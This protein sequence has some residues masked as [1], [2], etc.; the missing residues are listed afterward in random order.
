MDDDA[1]PA[2]RVD[3]RAILCVDQS[4]VAHQGSENIMMRQIT[5]TEADLDNAIAAMKQYG[6]LP[7]LTQCCIVAQALRRTFPVFEACVSSGWW[8]VGPTDDARA[9]AV[10]GASDIMQLFDSRQYAELRRRLPITI[11]ASEPRS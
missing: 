10:R 11:E 4:R 5:V 8:D 2:C 1:E 3:D 9:K 6:V 7:K